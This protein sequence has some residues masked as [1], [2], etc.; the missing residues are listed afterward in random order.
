[1]DSSRKPIQEQTSPLAPDASCDESDI[2]STAH[3]TRDECGSSLSYR[4]NFVGHTLTSWVSGQRRQNSGFA[5]R[6]AAIPTASS[7]QVNLE[8]STHAGGAEEMCDY[9]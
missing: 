9:R 8:A 3:V 6:K 1:M 7:K 4:R 5:S 2:G